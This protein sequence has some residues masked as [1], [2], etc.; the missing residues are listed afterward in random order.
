MQ[1]LV[2]LHGSEMLV[3]QERVDG[4]SGAVEEALSLLKAERLGPE[5]GTEGVKEVA[6]QMQRLQAAVE[7]QAAEM[8]HT[9]ARVNQLH[10]ELQTT[11][12][13]V[14]DPHNEH[15]HD[16]ADDDNFTWTAQ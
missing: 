13:K 6:Q 9:Q 2:Q 7:E 3:A 16:H 4:L 11:A 15:E 1:G 10:Q 14:V 8:A 5:S 12:R